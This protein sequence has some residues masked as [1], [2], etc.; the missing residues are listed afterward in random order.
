[1]RK[2]GKALFIGLEFLSYVALVIGLLTIISLALF[3]NLESC[4]F[5]EFQF[6]CDENSYDQIANL[7]YII[8]VIYIRT[9]L[10]TLL[11]LLGIF[12]GLRRIHHIKTAQLRNEGRFDEVEKLRN[13]ILRSLKYG[14]LFAVMIGVLLFILR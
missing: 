1:M 4:K 14:L 9:A 6:G 3:T 7:S 12:L 8:F 11:G 13:F 10:P 2:V 5:S